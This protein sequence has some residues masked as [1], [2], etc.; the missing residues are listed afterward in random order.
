MIKYHSETLS[1]LLRSMPSAI[2]TANVLNALLNG[3]TIKD[4]I[5]DPETFGISLKG[6]SLESSASRIKRFINL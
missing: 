2:N 1:T 3:Y 4:M 5:A 6:K